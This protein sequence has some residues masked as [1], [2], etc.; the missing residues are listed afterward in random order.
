MDSKYKRTS[1]VENFFSM[2]LTKANMAKGVFF[3]NLPAKINRSWDTMV[4]VDMNSMK[5]FDSH[6]SGSVNIFLYAKAEGEISEKPIK[7]LYQMESLLD[8][9]IESSSD[10]HYVI[11][12]N[13]RDGGYDQSRNFYYNIVNVSVIVK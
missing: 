10:E 4:L 7:K 11:R 5:D 1:S 13:W 12:A 2:M 3:G 9:A 8:N 6:V